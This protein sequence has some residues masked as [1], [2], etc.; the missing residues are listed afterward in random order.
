MVRVLFQQPDRARAAVELCHSPIFERD[1]NRAIGV[2]VRSVQVA[3]A[4]PDEIDLPV[5]LEQDTVC[6]VPTVDDLAFHI[7]EERLEKLAV[8]CG[9]KGQTRVRQRPLVNG[10]T[11]L[12]SRAVDQLGI[13]PDQI[14]HRANVA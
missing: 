8:I 12:L 11:T 1:E 13:P 5:A 2:Q 6:G 4:V 7:D 9:K 3:P 10:H 14:E